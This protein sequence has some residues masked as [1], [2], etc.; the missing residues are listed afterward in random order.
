VAP[1]GRLYPCERLIGEDRPDQPLRL[2]GN[3]LEGT[4][5]LDPT[6]SFTRCS[7]CNRC[8]LAFACDTTC[9]C[10]NFIRT[11]DVNQPD[12]LL[13]LL[14]KAAARATANALNTSALMGDRGI[15]NHRSK[16]NCYA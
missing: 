16:E 7:P 1:S 3:A 8:E 15:Y 9:R 14:N 11:G 13:C 12:G 10:S 4:D 5:F 6:T 2:P